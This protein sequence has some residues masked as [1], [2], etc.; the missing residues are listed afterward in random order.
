MQTQHA[1]NKYC[2]SKCDLIQRYLQKISS[3]TVTQK[4]MLL[5]F[6]TFTK[7]FDQLDSCVMLP[8]Q[9]IFPNEFLYCNMAMSGKYI[10]WM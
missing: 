2:V 10:G 4:W 6:T 7:K 9:F 3:F 8:A 1:Q 5:V